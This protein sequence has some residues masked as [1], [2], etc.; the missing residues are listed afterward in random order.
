MDPLNHH[1]EEMDT[2]NRIQA[3]V[4]DN[5]TIIMMVILII[6]PLQ[7]RL[8]LEVKHQQDHNCRLLHNIGIKTNG[9]IRMQKNRFYMIMMSVKVLMLIKQNPSIKM[10]LVSVRQLMFINLY[11]S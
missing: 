1:E 3:I 2:I 6:V 5:I 10:K 8:V 11:P 4:R 7:H 9:E